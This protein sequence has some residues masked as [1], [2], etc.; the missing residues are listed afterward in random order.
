MK[1]EV[2]VE[3]GTLSRTY[4]DLSSR[5]EYEESDYGEESHLLGAAEN[6]T[7]E[8]HLGRAGFNPLYRLSRDADNS[9]RFLWKLRHRIDRVSL[10][11]PT[12]EVRFENVTV[13]G[14]AYVGRRALPSILNSL[15]NTVESIAS[16]LSIISSKKTNFPILHNVSGIIKPG[17]LTLLLGPPG[18]GKT[19]L[20]R[21]LA[22]KVDSELKFSGEVTYNGNRMQEFVPQRTSAYIGQN[23]VHIPQMTVRETLTFS[24]KC[25][26]AGTVFDVLAELLK[27][28]EMLNIKPDPYIKALVKKA[29]TKQGQKEDIIT[30]Y[31]L[32]ILGL[33]VCADT[34]VGDELNR[35]ISGGQKRRVT[36]GEMLVSPV[37]VLFMDNISTGLD[38]SITSQIVNS[39]RQSVHIFNLTVLVSLL[40]PPPETFDLFDDIILLTEGKVVYQGPREHVLEFFE[41]MGFRCPERKG[42]ADFLQDVTSRK[43]QEQ[44]WAQEHQE[45]HYVSVDEFAEAYKSFRVGKEVD[46]ELS[47][48]FDRLMNH[49]PAALSGFKYGASMAELLRACFSREATMMKRNVFLYVFK[50][51]QM[52]I[53]AI[54]LATAYVKTKDEHESMEDGIVHLGSLYSG[55]YALLFTGFFEMPMIIDKLP[56]FYKQR[57]LLF[58]PSWAFSVSAAIIQIPVSLL[59]V[60]VYVLTT[61]YMMGFNHSLVRMLKLYVA[62]TF[63][64]QMSYSFFRCMGALTRDHVLANIAGCAGL[65]WVLVFSGFILSRS[66]VNRWIAWAFYTS[67][68]MYV[69]TAVSVNEFRSNSWSKALNGTKEA[70]GM[71]VLES[72]GL[73]ADPNWYW[74]GI[75]G[76]ICFVILFN[77]VFTL[78]LSYLDKHRKSPAVSVP[79]EA[80]DEQCNNQIGAEDRKA[81]LLLPFTPLS[82]S[83]QNITYSVDVPYEMNKGGTPHDPLSIL[84]GVS[85]AFRPGILTAL[86]GVS[87]AGKT[88]LL[89][90]LS[91]RKNNGYVD[92]RI[93]I[94]GHKKDQETFTRIS[95][96]CEQNDIHSPF[97][98]VYESLLYS[99]RLRLS[100]EIDQKT[101]EL[102]VDEVLG[103]VELTSLK[104]TLVGV[105]NISGLSLEQRK[106]LTIAVELV[107]NPSIIFMDEPTS[108]LDAQA[109]AI[110]MRTV[111]SAADTGRTVVCTIHQPSLEI[112]ESFDEMLLLTQGGE[113]MYFGPLGHRSQEMICYFESINGVRRMDNGYNPATWVLEVTTS[114]QEELLGIKFSE[115][116]KKSEL[117]RKNEAMI[118]QLSTPSSTSPELHFPVKCF[119]SQFKA[120]LWKQHKSYWRNTSY[121]FTRF[122]FTAIL[123]LMLGVLYWDLGSRRRSKSDILDGLGAM[124]TAVIFMGTAT[125][126]AVIPVVI[127]ERAVYYRERAAGMYSALPYSLAQVV[128]EIPY[129]LFQAIIFSTII[130]TMM[131]FEWTPTKLLSNL[132]FNFII[133]LSYIYYGMMIIA[134]SPN[135]E[136]AGIISGLIYTAWTLF[137]GLVIPRERIAVWWRWFPL[138]SPVSWCFYGLAVSQYGNVYSKLDSGEKV[139]DFIRSYFGFRYEFLVEVYLIVAGF[140]VFF[141]LAYAYSM[142]ALNFQ[143]R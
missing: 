80:L 103:L 35:G 132:Y 107:A 63:M 140:S 115:M 116:Y 22:G 69:Q 119:I 67:P 113:E 95:G 139:A 18:S 39:I 128:V 98:T 126:T 75:A 7:E 143:K 101:R 42:I 73:F 19:T 130:Y 6:L 104:D 8:V 9:E 50:I 66:A 137:S 33:E 30:G 25:R 142:K 91:G 55:M 40:Q 129:T 29:S 131:G 2:P 102:F 110:V 13:V 51:I 3:L 127:S 56:V 106:R 92:G 125:A 122:A 46:Q 70:L 64:G 49:H 84:N 11:L 141:V 74:F 133:L 58:Y 97:V 87:G 31:V 21:A 121:N 43:D 138:V 24:A 94:S 117:H 36:T 27:R 99:A 45:Y 109:A 82:I 124:N 48:P 60:T 54:V 12:V 28:E 90:I 38:S 100:P 114:S 96:Y 79:Q 47:V 62:Y 105:T 52:E 77:T 78:A 111:R 10:K 26:G 4:P 57:D 14:E 120:C 112:F 85:G 32:K 15:V 76:L 93:T 89:D 136:T 20:L 1:E 118:E 71:T 5:W 44:Y 23:D 34:I 108:G 88:T 123:A 86:M 59:E 68:L 53:L 37:N 134:A 81:M 83:F 72:R 41:C 17:R 65:V 135:Q 16:F 61:Y